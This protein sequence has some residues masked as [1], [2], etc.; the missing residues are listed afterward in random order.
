MRA[1]IIMFLI[2]AILTPGFLLGFLVNPWFLFVLCLLLVAVAVPFLIPRSETA[3][4]AV[5]PQREDEGRLL[6][7]ILVIPAIL[8]SLPAIIAALIYSPFFVLL[9]LLV[10]GPLVWVAFRPSS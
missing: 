1:L 10:M 5:G 3:S 8:V 6:I 4:R 9:I 2:V 7:W